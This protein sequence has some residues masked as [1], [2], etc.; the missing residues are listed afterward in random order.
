MILLIDNYDSFV[1]NLARTFEELGEEVRVFRNDAINVDGL[2]LLA[3]RAIVISPGPR[4]PRE[5]GVSLEVIRRYAAR[6]PIL[7]VC[8]GHQAIGEAFGGRIVRGPPTHGR[9]SVIRHDGRGIFSGLPPSF[10]A[11]RYHSL[12]VDPAT[13]PDE[14][15]PC[16]W[17]DDGTIMALRHRR[18]PVI[19][20]QFHP[21]S[22]L[23]EHGH[24]LLARFLALDASRKER[25]AS[26]VE[27][28][29]ASLDAVLP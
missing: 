11:A 20:V 6:V 22:V 23:T 10:R 28:P 17:S 5:A 2:S 13:L 14:L 1:H 16:A 7:G 15:E 29:A 9:A 3:I 19:G 26:R 25:D 21:E 12:V 18:F 4:T 24:A 8:L 27:V